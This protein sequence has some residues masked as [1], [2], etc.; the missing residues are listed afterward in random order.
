MKKC[1]YCGRENSDDAAHCSGCGT[2]FEN[3]NPLP[4]IPK[5]DKLTKAGF[6]IRALARII[7][8]VFG[9]F[10]GLMAGVLAGFGLAL[11]KAAGALSPGWQYRIHGFSLMSL[12]FGF[13]GITLYHFFCEGIYGATLGK[14]CCGIRVVSEDGSPCNLKGALIRTLAYYIDA[15]FFGLVGYNSMEKSAL[16]QRY[17]DVWGKLPSSKPVKL[18][19]NRNVLQCASRF[20]YFWALGVGLP[21]WQQV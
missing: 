6:W 12:A 14:L 4:I 18:H 21:W 8:G 16:N 20:L 1:S 3:L 15:L 2:E 11:L 19:L 9:L 13:L 10:I 7:D 17:G 5:Q